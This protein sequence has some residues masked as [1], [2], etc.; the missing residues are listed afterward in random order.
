[1]GMKAI[2]LSDIHIGDNSNTCWYQKQYHEQYLLK[3][4]EYIQANA[5]SIN[6]V[7][8]L[9]DV[10]DFWTYPCA[11][12]PP[13]FADIVNANPNVLGQNGMLKQLADQVPVTYINGNHDMNIGPA[14]I[15]QLGNIRFNPGLRYVKETPGG[16]VLLTHGSEYTIFN[17]Q[18]PTT[19]LAPLPAGHFVT[20][21]ISEY[22]VQ[23][24]LTPGQT[25]ADLPGDGIPGFPDLWQNILNA[26]LHGQSIAQVMIDM[27]CTLPG[28]SRDT[29]VTL[30]NGQTL[31]FAQ[32]ET[33][34]GN[35]GTQWIQKYGLN[36]TIKSA[37]ADYNGD[38]IAW[39]AQRDCLQ[40]AIDA[41]MA[42]L[43]HTH[44][45]KGGL[46][47]AMIGYINTGYM[48][49]AMPGG[50]PE[51]PITFGEI[52]LDS[53]QLSLLA[54][55]GPDQP[56]VPTS[57]P[58]DTLVYSPFSDFSCFI[59]ILNGTYFD[60]NLTNQTADQGWYVVPPPA[61]IGAMQRSRF[62]LQDSAGIHGSQG[63]AT[64]VNAQGGNQTVFTYTCPT[65]IYSNNCNPPPFRNKSDSGAW[66][67]NTVVK[68]GHPYFVDFTAE[69]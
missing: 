57:F 8:L 20:R 24:K 40:P 25:V 38:Y 52:D 67:N 48:C 68:G 62:W 32:A 23:S 47:E 39:W 30:L 4:F 54:T 9:G 5:A 59:S 49:P 6:E 17:A 28:V 53:G 58:N 41:D 10:F 37:N 22:L 12:S 64:Y 55:S 34:Y 42:I 19:S 61:K 18:D 44:T 21:A 45:A 2:I 27:F 60:M 14:D 16:R 50:T 66:Q 29:P 26:L 1:M 51:K 69:K 36:P 46:A 43:G 35:L 33:I 56:Y 15:A 65:G 63:S 3:A 11:R 13:A 31:T 7:I